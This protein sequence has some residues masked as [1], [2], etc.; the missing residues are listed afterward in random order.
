MRFESNAV[1]IAPASGHIVPEAI[2]Y[3]A[4][5]VAGFVFYHYF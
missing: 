2:H 3:F 5:F 4:L 1:K